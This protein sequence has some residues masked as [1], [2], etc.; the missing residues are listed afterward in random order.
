MLGRVTISVQGVAFLFGYGL[1]F[2]GGVYLRWSFLDGVEN[3][4]RV[5]SFFWRGLLERV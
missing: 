5:W 2:G 4:F 1:S 3:L